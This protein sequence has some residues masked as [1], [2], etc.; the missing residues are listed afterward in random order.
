[1][2]VC[3]CVCIKQDELRKHLIVT[4]TGEVWLNRLRENQL[5][6]TVSLLNG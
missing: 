2:C 5:R 3:V 1:M 6:G 4:L